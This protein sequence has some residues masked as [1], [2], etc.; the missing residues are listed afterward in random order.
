[1]QLTRIEK[2]RSEL[3]QFVLWLLLVLLVMITYLS[4]EQRQGN[5]ILLLTVV[6]LVAC[7]YAVGRERRLKK[8]QS[9]LTKE[10][11]EEQNKSAS[12]E[13]RLKELSGLYR[14]ISTVN[15][16]TAPEQTFDS[17]LRAALDLVGGNRGSLMLLNEEDEHLVITAAEG[18]SEDVVMATRQKLGEGV[19]GWVAKHRE[20]VLLGAEASKDDRFQKL[21]SQKHTARSSISVP[22]HLR[23]RVLG[24][25]N[26]SVVTDRPQEG[27]SEYDLRMLTIFAQHA[28]VAIENARLRMV[29][30]VILSVDP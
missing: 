13:G 21:F 28:S 4:Y 5:F 26:V 30:S 15:S 24:V 23:D 10:L 19:A 29:N 7:L 17:V 14:A 11:S 2:Q 18:I 16:G 20:P 9:E 8:L 27:L 1:M 3:L 12:L 25:I 6:S 22:L